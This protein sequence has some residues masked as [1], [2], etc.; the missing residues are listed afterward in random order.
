[1]DGNGRWAAKRGLPRPAG[2]KAGADNLRK[3]MDACRNRGIKY[4]TFFA[5]STENWKRPKEEV[6]ALMRL[7]YDYL[8]EA[9]RFTGKKARIMF[10]GSKEPFPEK[11]RERM[12]KLEQ[13]SVG[14]DSMT[15]MF[16]MNYGGRDDIVYAAR[17]LAE[18]AADGDIKP[19]D[20]DEKLFRECFTQVQ[21]P[22]P[23]LSYAPAAS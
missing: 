11:L 8:D 10:L 5:F 2:H 6:D 23:T 15:I 9:D 1:M 19:S 7:F 22:M 13:N 14:Y 3:I 17:R 20:I 4:A 18:A 12:I 16:A 21:H